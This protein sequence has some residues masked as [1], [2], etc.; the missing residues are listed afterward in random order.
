VTL[1]HCT[2]GIITNRTNTIDDDNIHALST[3][4]ATTPIITIHDSDDMIHNKNNDNI[5][6]NS[7]HNTGIITNI[8]LQ[9]Q[10]I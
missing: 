8:I 7:I 5:N 2:A 6:T 10:Y 4:T 1:Q 9:H 3:P